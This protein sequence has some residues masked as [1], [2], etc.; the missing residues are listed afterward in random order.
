AAGPG[1]D[2]IPGYAKRLPSEVIN[3]VYGLSKEEGAALEASMRAVVGAADMAA[4]KTL[5]TEF[6]AHA[7]SLVR[8]KRDQSG[9]RLLHRLAE[10]G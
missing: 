10:A 7:V 4:I 1:T 8:L 3:E 9:D 2:L 5:T 6:F